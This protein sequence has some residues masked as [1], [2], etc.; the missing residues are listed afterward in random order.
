MYF[1]GDTTFRPQ[2]HLVILSSSPLALLSSRNCPSLRQVG[3]L[4]TG[5]AS[6]RPELHQP[7]REIPFPVVHNQGVSLVSIGPICIPDQAL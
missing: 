7:N 4:S 5:P 6:Y 2:H 1:G 3:C